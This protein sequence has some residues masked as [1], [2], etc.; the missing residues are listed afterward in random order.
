MANLLENRD[1]KEILKC[2][3]VDQDKLDHYM[4]LFSQ[5]IAGQKHLPQNLSETCRKKFLL[6]AKLD[7]EKAK[8]KFQNFCYN[9]IT[10]KE[11]CS[12][13]V[14]TFEDDINKSFEFLYTIPMP[15]LTPQGIRITCLKLFNPENFDVLIMARAFTIYL[16]FRVRIADIVVGEAAILDLE[17]MR[18]QHYAKMF[19][20]TYLKCV[21][22]SMVNYP[23]LIKHL[24]IINCHP[25]LEKGIGLIKA[26]LPQK[27]AERVIILSNPKDMNKYIPPEYLPEDYGGTEKPIDHFQP[28]WKQYWLNL[29]DFYEELDRCKPTGPVP[30]EFKCH[31]SEFGIDGSFRKLNID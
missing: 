11:F 20:P 5:W 17:C 22:F 16:E 2:L 30:E 19:T 12:D 8:K 3:N 31:E 21:K 29:K 4:N 24:L 9:S 26:V 28:L 1:E 18:P 27:L 6:W 7:F 13:R 23:F 10:H 15:K 14:L 25:V